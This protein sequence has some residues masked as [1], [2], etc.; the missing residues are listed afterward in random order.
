MQVQGISIVVGRIVAAQGWGTSTNDGD[1]TNTRNQMV[2]LFGGQE[3]GGA[4]A[5]NQVDAQ[6]LPIDVTVVSGTGRTFN[7][8]SYTAASMAVLFLMFAVTSGGRTL[9]AERAAGTLPRLLVTPTTPL[10]VLVG[11]MG[12]IVLTGFLQMVLL[13]GATTL[14]G[15]Y[16]GPPV[17]VLAAILALVICASGVGALISAWS[18]SQGQA[19]AIGTAVTLVGSAVSGSFFPR[20]GLPGWVQ[21]VSLLTPNAWG[22]E[23]F[24][25][26]QRGRGLAGIL[27]Q[28]GWVLL[29]TLVYYGVALLGFRRQFE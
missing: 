15:A 20:A 21:T 18:R 23:I 7:W 12:G 29:L 22:I 24:S 1:E 10:T 19:G 16:W 27:D 17:G 9:L 26:L 6:A 5:F 25:A 2:D 14:A 3:G 8:I 4:A 13:W 11:K 28:L